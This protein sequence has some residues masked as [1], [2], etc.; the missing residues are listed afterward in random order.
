MARGFVNGTAL[1]WRWCYWLNLITCGLSIILFF[2]FYHPPNYSLLHQGQSMRRELK[3][4]D[5][6]GLVLYCCG[7]IMLMLG[8]TWGGKLY[9][10]NSAKIIG[11][12]VG[13]FATLGAFG[14]WGEL[15]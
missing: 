9:P 14:A 15:Q 10:W 13:G 3:R 6:L 12:L 7:L 11:L 2:F 4:L 8:I 1:G 5:Y